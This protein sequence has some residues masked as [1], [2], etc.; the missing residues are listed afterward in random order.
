[1]TSREKKLGIVFGSLLTIVVLGILFRTLTGGSQDGS[2]N[3]AELLIQ[4]QDMESIVESKEL[5]NN[6]E[7]WLNE[8]T[9]YHQSDVVA[10]SKLLERVSS[11][12]KSHQLIVI[13][14]ELTRSEEDEGADEE[15]VQ[16]FNH[17]SVQITAEG[18]VRNIVQCIHEIQTPQNFTGID[19]LNLEVGESGGYRVTFL[20]K[21]WFATY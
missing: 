14:Q 21:H 4:L 19:D 2:N 11:I 1:M 13:N 17:V 9:P 20:I 10:S 6:R 16:H 12:L 7:L 5:W 8:N 18:E 15:S 3:P